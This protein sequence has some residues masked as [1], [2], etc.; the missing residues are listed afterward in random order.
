MGLV[1]EFATIPIT[2]HNLTRW[3][4]LPD[5]NVYNTL[6]E[7][8]SALVED[9]D[10]YLVLPGGVGTMYELF[11]VLCENDVEK[12]EK[13]VMV[14]DPTGVYQPLKELL[15][16]MHTSG[17]V[18]SPPKVSFFQSRQELISALSQIF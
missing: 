16:N 12:R 1:R 8:Q 11:Q 6:R 9:S 3:D 10:A 18:T 5:E 2:G 7:R 13:P 4:P 17:Y 14:Y 15:C